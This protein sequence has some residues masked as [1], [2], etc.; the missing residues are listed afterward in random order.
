MCQTL[1]L[2]RI[3][4]K[5]VL[6][7]PDNQRSSGKAIVNLTFQSRLNESQFTIRASVVKS[8]TENLPVRTL[9]YH[10]WP[11]I[12]DLDLAD[13]DF[14]RSAPIDLLIGS[15]L[16]ADILLEGLRKGQPNEPIA[17]QSLLGWLISGKALEKPPQ[18]TT[19]AATVHCSHVSLDELDT[20]VKQFYAIESIPT[21][22]QYTPEEKWCRDFYAFRSKSSHRK[23]APNCHESFSSA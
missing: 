23:I 16:Y 5:S 7:L 8:V 18:V 10:D 13:P 12:R 1:K 6:K 9:T 4:C 19:E 17:Q 2:P 11:H 22:E 21:E 3:S 14:N 20:L 15:D